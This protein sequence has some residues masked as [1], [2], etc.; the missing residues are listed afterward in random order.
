METN[1]TED[2]PQRLEGATAVMD[3][4]SDLMREE[5]KVAEET[6]PHDVDE[7]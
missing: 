3:E 5:E 1:P 4:L 6:P 7:T 2:E